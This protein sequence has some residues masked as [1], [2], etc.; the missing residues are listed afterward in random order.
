MN[1]APELHLDAV[2]VGGGPAGATASLLL[3]Q[4]GWRVALTERGEA[5][6]DKCCGHCLSAR[7]LP[8]LEQLGLRSIVD[9]ATVGETASLRIDVGR[10]RG[11]HAA[12]APAPRSFTVPLARGAE[13]G[14]RLVERR[15]LDA[16]LVDAAAT[17]GAT[18]YRSVAAKV[19]ATAPWRVEL[20]G[21]G[22]APRTPIVLVAP[23]LIGADGLGSG[24]ARTLGWT[25]PS[26]G[27]AFGFSANLGC[28]A[29]PSLGP[30]EVAMH[31]LSSGYLG[32]ARRRD[33]SI[34][35]AALVRA[36]EAPRRPLDFVAAMARAFPES[37]GSHWRD[38]W[39]DQ[40][41]D[42][43]RADVDP[44]LASGLRRAEPWLAAGPMSWRPSMVAAPGVALIGDAAGYVE[45]FTGE[46][47]AWAFESAAAL[48]EAIGA[49][50][51]V[52][53]APEAARYAALW[54]TR[55]GA[56]QRRCAM[57]A[58]L[59]KRPALLRCAAAVAPALATRLTQRVH[60]APSAIVTK[61]VA[62]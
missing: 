6:R 15:I 5:G 38:E 56:A 31:L 46:G 9:A 13:R 47:M 45:P 43:R 39:R 28:A 34:H 52:F 29:M 30:R 16:L 42:H 25:P 37:F 32:A 44:E 18:I 35:I 4:A 49:T 3:A 27:R 50:P 48:R 33:G 57:V 24:I 14:G 1:V 17:A 22:T 40:S 60:A 61:E 7:A 8:L 53:G 10:E 12:S 2:V 51:G 62:A 58:A 54:R 23:L 20:R 11:L 36:G 59:L 21:V 19:V 55:V 41:R 26:P